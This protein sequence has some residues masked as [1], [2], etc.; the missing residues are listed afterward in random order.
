MTLLQN[1]EEVFADLSVLWSEDLTPHKCKME[2]IKVLQS[3]A[4]KNKY[5]R[6]CRVA[7]VSD[8]GSVTIKIKPASGA[9]ICFNF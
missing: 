4:N 7:K 9:I 2:L 1:E 3:W 8:D 5:V 6:E